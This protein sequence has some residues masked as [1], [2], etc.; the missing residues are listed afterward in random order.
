MPGIIDTPEWQELARHHAQVRD[1]HLRD[2]FAADPH[3]GE[4]L[5]IEAGDLYLD[6]S[7]NRLTADT[8]TRLVALA[9]R[10]GVEALRDA[11]FAGAA[12][13]R[14]RAPVGA[15]RGAPSAPRTAD[16]RGRR[17]RRAPRPRGPRPHERLRRSGP[18]RRL[19]RP[20][21]AAHPQHHQHRHRGQRPRAS[22]GLRGV[23]RL[24]RPVADRAVRVQ[25]RRDRLLREHP[26][27][28]PRR[29]AVHRRLQDLHHPR[30]HDERPHRPGVDPRRAARR[31]GRRQALRR[32]VDERGRGHQVR[33]RPHEHVRVLGLGRWPIFLRLR[34]RPV[35]HARRRTERV[36]V[37][38]RR[39]PPNRRALPR[40][41]PSRRTCRCSSGSSA[42]G[43]TTSLEPR[44]SRSCRTTSTSLTSP[45]TCSSSTW[46]ATGSRSGATASRSPGRP[47]RSS[48]ASPAPTASTPTTSSSTRARS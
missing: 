48:G 18:L 22:H 39:L 28:R 35:A 32:R 1:V 41:L 45:T 33:Y 34:H 3:R 4:T 10:A 19:D 43:T 27:P 47:V 14:D 26:R 16:P 15:A 40:T 13:Q 38:A 46:R 30:D 36:P 8:M 21:R 17:R 29:D 37:D 11:M 5:C 24:Q 9:R 44:P 12:D 6:Y 20:H 42:S 31:H 7:K 23:A 2:L 25:C